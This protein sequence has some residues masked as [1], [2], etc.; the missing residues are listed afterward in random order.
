MR[1]ILI[2]SLAE[3]L[4]NFRGA[5]ISELQN[6]GCEVHVAAPGLGL[7]SPKRIQLEAYGIFAHDLP[8]SRNGMNIVGD[9]NACLFLWRILRRVRPDIVLSYTIKPI[10]YGS[11]ISWV[12]QV[13]VRIA[14]ITGLGYIF[15]ESNG[16][17][18]VKYLIKRL[19]KFSVRRLTLIFFQNPDDL[20]LFGHLGFLRSSVRVSLVNGSGIDLKHFDFRELREKELIEFG[21]NF[22]F[23]GRLLSDKGLREF[24]Q[25]ANIIRNKYPAVRFTIAGSLDTNPNS[26]SKAEL[27]V[28]IANGDIDYIGHLSDVRP[29]IM[30]CSVFVLPSY[31]EG[32]PR[33]VLEAMAIG[34]AVITTDA[35]G[36]R[37]TVRHGVSGLLVAP[38]S[39]D[40]LVSAMERCIKDP[41]LVCDMGRNGRNYA[42][43]KYDVKKVNSIMLREMGL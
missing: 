31:R 26:V 41:K 27:D 2:A 13:P 19:Y 3:S 38:R 17:H 43:E 9:V 21:F 42:E 30:A 5:L 1:I 20:D 40:S 18:R 32:T 7:S 6:K 37:E 4:I 25:A 33:T 22:L 12:A 16:N 34:R 11:I 36:C 24:V 39:T 28:W 10:I 23:I 15:T 35:P 8:M 14:L 29:A